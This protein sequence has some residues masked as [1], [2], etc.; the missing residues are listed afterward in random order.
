MVRGLV[1]VYSTVVASMSALDYV[2]ST[3]SVSMSAACVSLADTEARQGAASQQRPAVSEQ[4]RQEGRLRS[5]TA[6][7]RR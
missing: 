6:Q 2:H 5:V 7:Q 3:V 1:H 4:Q